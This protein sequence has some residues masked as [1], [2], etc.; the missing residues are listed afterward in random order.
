MLGDLL[1]RLKVLLMKRQVDAEMDEELRYHLEREAAK[2]SAASGVDE[3]EALRRARVALG[4]A[5][6]VRQ[7]V[8]D[9]RGTR[10]LE[11]LLADL[12][13]G[14]RVLRK[15]PGFAVVAVLTLGLGIGACT[16]VF[17]LVNA[18]LLR[19]LP[20]WDTGRLVYLYT[21][22]S[23]FKDVP[24]E[25]FGPAY[26]DYFDLKAQSHS[27]AGMTS[28]GQAS[29]G[30]AGA[31]STERVG[32]AKVDGDFF[33]VLGARPEIGRAITAV[34]D[35]PGSD[36]VA[37]ISHGLWQR[38]FAGGMDVL[39]KTLRLDGR[40]YRVVGVM[41]AEFG[42]PHD[43]DLVTGIS[44]IKRTD[45]WV[46][47]ALTVREFS[48]RDDSSGYAVGRL[49]DGVTVAEAQAEMAA[50]MT[51][52]DLLHPASMRGWS[53]YV[54]AFAEN[55]AGGVRPL[56]WSLLAAVGVVLLI[57]CGNAANLLLARAASRTHELGVRATLGAGRGRVMRQML[58]ESL[59]L[60]LGGGVVGVGLAYG[61]VQ[62]L[63]LLNPGNIPRMETAALDGRVLA[64]TVVVSVL[65][66]VLF[67]ILPAVSVARVNLV[68]FLKT[69]GNRGAVGTRGRLQ[70]GLI[71]AEVALVVMML[72]AAGLL[73]H[74]Y[75]NVQRVPVGFSAQTVSMGVRL[76][77]Q[78]ASVPQ[79]LEFYR[80]LL[81]RAKAIPG[82]QAAGMIT[83]LPLA[84]TEDLSTLWVD[85]YANQP[86]QLVMWR[87]VTGEY[88]SAMG[89]PL[90]AGRYF[91]EQDT[92]KAP[93]VAIVN[94]AFAKTYFAGR[95]PVGLRIAGGAPGEPGRE[96]FTVVG[97]VGNV[98]DASLEAEARPEEF[99]PMWQA[100]GQDG[101]VVIRTGA[102]A[103]GKAGL[104][105]SDVA[106]AM[107][108]ILRAMDPDLALT[109]IRTMGERVS[110]ASALRRFQTMLLLGFA[111][112]ALLLSLVGLYGL[113][114]YG[115]KRRTAEI[116][117]RIALGASRRWVLG[118]VVRQGL[119]LVVFGLGIGL[120]AALAL[121]RTMAGMLFGV[122]AVDPVTFLA[123]PGLLL[124][125]AVLAA[126]IPG[127]RAAGVEPVVA[128]RCE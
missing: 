18:V 40:T 64:F 43:Y 118:M 126:V 101:F 55:A 87:G 32:A 41:P 38:M 24:L 5:E 74:S 48:L 86:H 45:V 49:K 94:E 12:H 22:N 121:T 19:A 34:D 122:R 89:I 76:N 95:N 26:A 30:L 37:V 72:A 96:E 103:D 108:G 80:T 88:F 115:V 29:Y 79:R 116:G 85:G 53:G 33:T 57:A 39:T 98:Q 120:A 62:G 21:P 117:L 14:V 17:S 52:L 15:S 73:L 128:L 10:L 13:Y 69:G 59:L 125:A 112:T 61:L 124:A 7:R 23:T 105:A 16:A 63:L 2:V 35:H 114:A 27:Y 102:G 75:V 127:W 71:V 56:M 51:R 77:A 20:Y 92:A 113:L 106:L 46:P 123:V 36:G 70:S 3:D 100:D 81:E 97:M 6:Q 25:A 68:E 82:V 65:T 67:G 99:R 84:N 90:V 83:N 60:G 58:A 110:E 78:Y 4:G 47:L 119:A 104:A 1:Y 28:F 11:D 109:D 8:R 91:S 93:K 9:G 111:A 66:S 42:Y 31:H 44:A 54:K 107:Q 50:I